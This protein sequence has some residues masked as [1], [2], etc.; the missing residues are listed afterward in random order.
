[1]D[2]VGDTNSL[3]EESNIIA[4]SVDYQFGIQRARSHV[5][6]DIAWV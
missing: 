3:G 5:G 6:M 1:M 2:A 4:K